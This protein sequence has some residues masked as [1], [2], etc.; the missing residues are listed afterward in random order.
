MKTDENPTLSDL[1]SSRPA[2][3]DYSH[4]EEL[5]H[6][7]THGIGA[8]LSLV[9]TGVLV[10][11]ATLQGD[12]WKILSASIYGLSLVSLYLMSTL[13]H[14]SRS[15]RAKHLFKILDHTAIYLLIAGTYTPL[16]LVSLRGVWGW[17]LFGVLWGLS[18]V[19]IFMKIVWIGR[20]KRLSLG[21][22]LTMGWLIVIAIKPVL[23]EVPP[24]GLLWLL[25]GGCSYTFGVVFYIW[26]SL[27][28]H[29]AIWHLF[30]LGGSICHF[31]AVL[32]YVL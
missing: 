2:S 5:A 7:V 8:I 21:I 32:F 28:Y 24:G 17:S 6:S 3:V 9:G 16:T 29:H 10:S 14:S 15:A 27:P 20:F 11:R 22:Y 30:V 25:A 23:T 26:K 31:F 19:G 1:H 12:P 13:Y 18:A 4:S